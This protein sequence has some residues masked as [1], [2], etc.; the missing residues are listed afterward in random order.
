MNEITLACQHF[1]NL[2]KEQ[3]ERL[4]SMDKP[5]KDF[6][7]MDTITIGIAPG[8]GIGPII[9]EQAER[10][11]KHLLKDEIASGK[12][13]IKDIEGLTIENAESACAC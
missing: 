8:D 10:V 13:V 4:K 6:S 2:L 9:M 7:K 1:E 12:V 3:L 5:V 11:L